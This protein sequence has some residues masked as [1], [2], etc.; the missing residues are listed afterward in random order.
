MKRHDV[1][2]ALGLIAYLFMVAA[3]LA[4]EPKRVKDGL[5]ALYPFVPA[6]FAVPDLEDAEEHWAMIVHGEMINPTPEEPGVTFE[7]DE[8]A[9]RSDEGAKKIVESLSKSGQMTLEVWLKPTLLAQRGPARIVSISAGV[10]NERD[11][12]LGQENGRYVFRLRTATGKGQDA[13]QITQHTTPKDVVLLE[14]HHVMV[15][16]TLCSH[17]GAGTLR[18]FVNGKLA[19]ERLGLGGDFSTW[20]FFPLLL[21]NEIDLNRQWRGT[22]YLVALYD[23]A[24]SP[25]EVQANFAAGVV[26]PK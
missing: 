21:G 23:R 24:L 9:L 8:S 6:E 11:F 14:R 20:D 25:E 2:T 12:T 22:L 4:Q 19:M 10:G 7:A 3:C 26:R 15:T 18:L 13:F 1:A 16:Y 17:C 5:V